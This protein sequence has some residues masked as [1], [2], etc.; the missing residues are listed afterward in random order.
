MVNA[1]NIIELNF[2]NDTLVLLRSL[3]PDALTKEIF[4]VDTTELDVD[5]LYA[6]V[7][8]LTY[9]IKRIELVGGKVI[10]CSTE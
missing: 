10:D 6:T 4:S 8:G 7:G 5:T 2:D 3:D 9:P 1:V